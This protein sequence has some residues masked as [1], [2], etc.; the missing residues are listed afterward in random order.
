[1]VVQT[2]ISARDPHDIAIISDYISSSEPGKEQKY[3]GRA[4][5]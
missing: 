1:V 5:L 3:N 4:S 2:V